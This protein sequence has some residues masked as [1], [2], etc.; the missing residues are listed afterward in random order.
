MP[1][2][3]VIFR[4]NQPS[5]VISIRSIQTTARATVAYSARCAWRVNSTSIDVELGSTDEDMD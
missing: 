3:Q 2:S 5:G 1:A 4:S